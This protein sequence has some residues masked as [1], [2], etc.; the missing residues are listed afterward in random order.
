MGVFLL[1]YLKDFLF[2][3]C[4]HIIP[5]LGNISCRINFSGWYRHKKSIPNRH[6]FYL[7][8]RGSGTLYI[9]QK[10][11]E[12]QQGSIV[13]IPS[14]AG[15]EYWLVPDKGLLDYYSIN[16]SVSI[17]HHVAE[18]W[19][20]DEK[21]NFHHNTFQYSPENE[22][23]FLP[24]SD[25]FELS[26]TQIYENYSS[27]EKTLEKISKSRNS[28]QEQDYWNQSILMQQFLY[29]IT[30]QRY[31]SKENGTNTM[32]VNQIINL[33]N[34]HYDQKFE[35]VDLCNEVKLSPCYFIKI[36]KNLT[37]HTPIEYLNIVRI[38]KA[39]ELLVETNLSISQIAVQVGYQ[40]LYYFSKKFKKIIGISPQKFRHFF[41]YK[42]VMD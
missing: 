40:D 31:Y 32:R 27:I 5:Y 2:N 1:L 19:S 37:T 25:P 17:V 11:Y 35:L 23:S 9:N 38:N 16:F 24:R 4:E 8:T 10:E 33:I 20:Y 28:I 26:Y 14:I 39:K 18:V 34:R 15:L 7:I 6:E 21:T 3:K 36:F 42:D 13:Y 12:V 29:E 30:H 41:D 22:W